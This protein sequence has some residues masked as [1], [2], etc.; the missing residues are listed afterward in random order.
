MN[1]EKVNSSCV[2]SE[3]DTSDRFDSKDLETPQDLEVVQDDEK[4]FLRK[5][6]LLLMPMFG[7]M[8]FFSYLDRSNIGN[9]K[10]AGLMEDIGL[11]QSQF[12][13]ASAVLY[14]TYISIQIPG[15]LLF[16]MFK[17]NYYLAC[18]MSA[19]ALVT[20]FSVFVNSYGSLVT[21]RVLIGLFEGSFYSCLS[22]YISN[23]YQPN[24]MGRRFAYLFI[25]SA[26]SSA[27]GGLIATGITEIES[28]PLAKWKYLYLIE[29]L[30][31]MVAVGFVFFFLP[32][33]PRFLAK[34]DKERKIWDIRAERRTLFLGS[35][36]F[37]KRQVKE[38][39]K[40]SKL[41]FSIIIQFC[42]DICMY[43]FT[44][45]LPS[46]L[47]SLGFNQLQS[48]YLTI[49]VYILAGGVF[50]TVAIL[51]DRWKIRGP[52]IVVLNIIC[53]AGY[54]ILMTVHNDAVRYFACYLITFALYTNV[55]LNETWLAGNSA[56]ID[57]RS[58]S[59]AANQTFGNVAGIISPLVYRSS[60]YLLGHAFTVG[61]LV[62][63]CLTAGIQ[64]YLFYRINQDRER[65]CEMDD[66][67]DDAQ[68]IGD[69]S[70]H[71]KYMI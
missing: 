48:Q 70:I 67:N 64:S 4:K 1:T 37:D 68:N 18:M 71:F 17:A 40:D 60:P 6:D 8:Y 51:S 30:L 13:T 52:I 7:A 54:I 66:E 27:F 28:G 62:V 21:T 57:K 35:A 41:Y 44:T 53:I 14:S 36:E 24:E 33:E 39:F 46:I 61:C 42:Q 31:T 9:A 20:I 63:S 43:G 55:G 34:N 50:L 16:R 2:V 3:L 12:S 10:L 11:T 22:V 5:M 56:P 69:K 59:I 19:W 25:F 49:P 29:G 15:V 65:K 32:S 45:F 38:A 26:L 23:T 47:F 58:T